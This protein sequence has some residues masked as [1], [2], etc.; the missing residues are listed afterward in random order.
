M[1]LFVLFFFATI[2]LAAI[3]ADEPDEP[4]D[5]D[6]MDIRFKYVQ[7]EPLTPE[8]QKIFDN[9]SFLCILR[10]ICLHLQKL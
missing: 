5:L 8:E 7:G 1:K 9:V 10:L 6:P 2:L 3:E 4:E